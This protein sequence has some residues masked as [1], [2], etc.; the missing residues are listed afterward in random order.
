MVGDEDGGLSR[1]GSLNRDFRRDGVSVDVK[2]GLGDP[3]TVDEVDA[4]VSKRL[5]F[6]SSI[7]VDWSSWSQQTFVVLHKSAFGVGGP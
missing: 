2:A 6:V 7:G 4:G 1:T 3:T 5:F